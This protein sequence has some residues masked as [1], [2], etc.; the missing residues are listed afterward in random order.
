MNTEQNELKLLLEQLAQPAFFE[1][2]GEVRFYNRLA[3]EYRVRAGR[4][5]MDLLPDGCGLPE[6]GSAPVHAQLTLSAGPADASILPYAG[7]RLYLLT[8]PARTELHPQT[9]LSVAQS[10]RTPLAN[11]LAGAAAL[12][13]KLEAL[14][15]PDLQKQ[16]ASMNRAYYQLLRLACNLT[17]MRGVLMDELHLRREKAELTGFFRKLFDR[18]APLLTAAGFEFEYTCTAKPFCGWIDRQRLERAVWD[19]LSNAAKFTPKGGRITA[20][21]EYTHAAALLHIR[22]TGDGMTPDLLADAFTA[23]DRDFALGDP[24]WGAGF[25]L[26]LA[27]RIAQL[28]GGAIFLE[29]EPGGGTTA[30]LSLSLQVPSTKELQFRSPT[31]SIDY[32]GGYPHELVELSNVLPYTEFDSSRVN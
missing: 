19:L 8:P 14:E 4:P 5:V 2:D 21:L 25:G 27:E 32:T 15:D 3:G 31:A 22:D 18:A 9:L 28:H 26:P 30:T 11:L 17:D 7:G 13:P 20:E 16:T 6:A 10:I 29:S 24:R 23:Y 12:F 1:T